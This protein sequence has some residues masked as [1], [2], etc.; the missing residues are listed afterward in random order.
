MTRS[1]TFAALVLLAGCTLHPKP[2]PPVP[3]PTPLVND[4]MCRPVECQGDPMDPG[5]VSDQM[6]AELKAHPCGYGGETNADR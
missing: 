3:Q 6:C 5:G 2:K 4:L 1:V